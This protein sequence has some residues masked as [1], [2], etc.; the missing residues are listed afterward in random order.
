MAE[1]APITVLLPVRNGSAYVGQAIESVLGQTF[2]DFRLV[3]SDNGSTDD[4]VARVT[5]YLADARVSLVR[6]SG[7]L[8]MLAHFNKCLGMLESPCYMLLCHDDFLY[9]PEALETAFRALEG[10]P[11]VSAVYCDMAYVDSAGEL[12]QVRHFG[13]AGVARGEKIARQSVIAVRNL[14]G[15]PLL[16]RT[17]ATRGL[18]YDRAQPYAADLDLS[19]AIS[20]K[21]HIYHVPDA[22]IANR[23]HGANAT[24]GLFRQ[25]L[26]Q[27]QELA[28]KHGIALGSFERLRMSFNAWSVALQKWAF[29]QYIDKFR[30]TPGRAP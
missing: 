25:A 1:P 2:R 17:Q 20:G 6:Q 5:G 23:Y 24:L 29:F 3:V 30:K 13:R 11:G 10:N 7:D 28:A 26:G 4:T 8:D 16:V 15:I 12:I 18:Q 21:G 19:I 22:M 14:F 27:M 9:R